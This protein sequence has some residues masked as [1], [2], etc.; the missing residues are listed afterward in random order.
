MYTFI[1]DIRHALLGGAVTP[2][3]VFFVYVWALWVVKAA[4]RA[5]LPAVADPDGAPGLAHDRPRAG[6]QRARAGVPPL[7]ASVRAERP[8]RDHRGRRRRRRGR[9]PRWPGLL[10]PGAA[11][12]QGRQARG[13]RRRASPPQ[14]GTRRRPRARLR[15]RL[16]AGRA[17]PRC[18]GRSPTRASAASRRARRSSTPAPT[19]CA[20]SPTGSRTCATASPFRRSRVFGQVGCLAG[21]T[22]A[23]RR[24]AFVPAVE[25]LEGQTAF[26]VELHV[27][28]D[29]VLTN[30]LLRRGWR[31]VYQSTALVWTDAPTDWRVV[32]APAAALGPLEPARDVALPAL[33]ADASRPRR[34]LRQPTS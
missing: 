23:Y 3:M 34:D 17:A 10:R 25:A 27:G 32:L 31:T 13:D 12:R 5:A 6:V 1:V 33:A 7:L 24:T 20:G 26:G 14:P 19:R 22:I 16:G 15:H 29:R 8:D 11:D 4:R 21:R 30:E 9:S 28:D 2:F 18:C